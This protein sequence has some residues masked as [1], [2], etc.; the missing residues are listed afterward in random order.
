MGLCGNDQ[1]S[2]FVGVKFTNRLSVSDYSK[3][4]VEKAVI[5]QVKRWVIIRN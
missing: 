2:A 5:C 4:M 1:V 3:L